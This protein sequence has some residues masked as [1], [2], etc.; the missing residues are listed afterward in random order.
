M[1]SRQTRWTRAIKRRYGLS[2]EAFDA[3]LAR[4]GGVCGICKK[5]RPLCVYHCHVTGKVR[6]LL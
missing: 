6:G 5:H 3:L 1:V 4:Q 2:R